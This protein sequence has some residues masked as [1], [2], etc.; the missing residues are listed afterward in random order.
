MR[1]GGFGQLMRKFRA[2]DLGL[3]PDTQLRD[4]EFVEIAD[5]PQYTVGVFLVP[6]VR[7]CL[8]PYLR[9]DQLLT[10]IPIVCLLARPVVHLH[11][12]REYDFGGTH[13]WDCVSCTDRDEHSH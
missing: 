1:W 10:P 12:S 2:P 13:D 9:L 5:F 11:A 6:K 3:E 4:I 8:L 7:A